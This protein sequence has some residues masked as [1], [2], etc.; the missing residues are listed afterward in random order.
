MLISP[1]T[2]M[3]SF[4]AISHSVIARAECV[5]IKNIVCDEKRFK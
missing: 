3:N 1:E 4:Q 2:E 5:E